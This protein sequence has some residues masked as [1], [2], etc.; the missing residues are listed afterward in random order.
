MNCKFLVQ[1][2][3]GMYMIETRA[4]DEEAAR[5]QLEALVSGTFE[6]QGIEL[7]YAASKHSGYTY[8]GVLNRW[9]EVDSA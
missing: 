5:E 1:T 2:S 6:V 3:D 7:A 8:I 9:Y 4:A